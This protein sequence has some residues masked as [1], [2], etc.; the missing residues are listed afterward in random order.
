MPLLLSIIQLQSSHPEADENTDGT[1]RR[2]GMYVTGVIGVI[3]FYV[4]VLAVGIWAAAF[5]R[6]QASQGHLQD[7]MMLANRRLG[8]LLGIF[9][10]VG[11]C[12]PRSSPRRREKIN[13]QQ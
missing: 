8:P 12:L 4:A 9:T 6:R 2:M 5:K 7:D 10:L 13:F 1:E 3:V 11:N